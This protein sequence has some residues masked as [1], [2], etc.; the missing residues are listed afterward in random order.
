MSIFSNLNFTNYYQ[1]GSYFSG[2][3]G[4]FMNER[5]KAFKE[6]SEKAVTKMVSNFSETEFGFS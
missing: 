5:I 1:K 3:K 6:Y 4:N 2:Q